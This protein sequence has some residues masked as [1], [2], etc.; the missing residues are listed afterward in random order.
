VAELAEKY[1]GQLQ[2]TYVTHP[3]V[4]IPGFD[5]QVEL[6]VNAQ[7]PPLSWKPDGVD[8]LEWLTQ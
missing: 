8:T 4:E 3:E 5:G 7:K 6:L 2:S 1:T